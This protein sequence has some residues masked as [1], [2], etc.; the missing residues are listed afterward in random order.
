MYYD[1]Q[2]DIKL[3]KLSKGL[4]IQIESLT[5]L[6]I[7]ERV[8]LLIVDEIVSILSQITSLLNSGTFGQN[9]YNKILQQ[10]RSLMIDSKTVICMDA[11]FTDHTAELLKRFRPDSIPYSIHN[12]STMHRDLYPKTVHMI[13][14]KFNLVSEFIDCFKRGEKLIFIAHS[15]TIL[16]NIYDKCKIINP[17]A[18]IQIYTGDTDKLLKRDHFSNLNEHWNNCDLILYNSSRSN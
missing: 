1:V 12:N 15:K 11:L 10:F 6:I 7:D 9:R 17:D 13:D 14:T 2:N 3:S 18:Q 4:I 16:E 5:R 8:D